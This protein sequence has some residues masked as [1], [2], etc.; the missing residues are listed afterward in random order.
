MAT[1]QLQFA[2]DE[3]LATLAGTA[4]NSLRNNDHLEIVVADR[5]TIDSVG[6]GQYP[7]TVIQFWIGDEIVAT[8]FRIPNIIRKLDDQTHVPE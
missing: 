7:S 5:Y 2:F 1:F 8:F 6:A 4:R 3:G